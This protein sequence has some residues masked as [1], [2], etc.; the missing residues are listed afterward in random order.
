MAVTREA[1]IGLYRNM[2]RQSKKWNSYNYRTYALRKIRHEF[3]ENKTLKDQE[4]IK[5]T[6]QFGVQNLEVIKRQV[7]LGNLYGGRPLVI[8]T[9]STLNTQ[10]I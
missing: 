7:I 3:R 9:K 5:D 1:I 8:E 6:F 4:K 10:H 2:I